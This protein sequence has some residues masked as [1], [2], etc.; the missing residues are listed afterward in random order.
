MTEAPRAIDANINPELKELEKAHTEFRELKEQEKK[1]REQLFEK[2]SAMFGLV[3]HV[4][5]ELSGMKEKSD[6][7]YTEQLTA[8]HRLEETL[9]LSIE[10][11]FF[12]QNNSISNILKKTPPEQLRGAVT[13]LEEQNGTLWYKARFPGNTSAEDKIG[14]GDILES[15]YKFV[16]VLS[17]DG[18]PVKWGRLTETEF[19]AGVKRIGYE[20]QNGEYIQILS[21][22]LFKPVEALPKAPQGNSSAVLMAEIPPSFQSLEAKDFPPAAQ[23]QSLRVTYAS[24]LVVDELV[25]EYYSEKK[26]KLADFKKKYEAPLPAEFEARIARIE[27]HYP[28]LRDKD[29]ALDQIP[30]LTADEV[31]ELRKDLGGFKL[32]ARI[33]KK[34]G[35]DDHAETGRVHADIARIVAERA[36][37]NPDDPVLKAY[38]S[39]EDLVRALWTLAQRE[40]GNCPFALSG[41]G[42]MGIFQFNLDGPRHYKI[43]PFSTEESVKGVLAL[44]RDNARTFNG[45]F[46]G[47]ELQ[48]AFVVA[49][50][51]GASV[52]LKSDVWDRS[53]AD[54]L[55]LDDPNGYNRHSP[56]SYLR[57]FRTDLAK[58]PMPSANA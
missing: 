54:I 15:K 56:N 5:T 12:F 13:T 2:S 58:M 35:L 49:H 51:A 27:A 48:N 11:Q 31:L 19:P 47:Q 46:A 28:Y 7:R 3:S 8:F 18:S 42:C 45:K 24:S 33:F 17:K 26:P 57:E 36:K 39:P 21:G 44:W 29:D 22:D 30:K 14:L 37:A 4:M 53:V 16:Q 55:G 38:K 50:A 32:L 9:K 10:S 34:L 41:T 23:E 1:S 43:N 52:A 6:P 40:S 20:D 25:E